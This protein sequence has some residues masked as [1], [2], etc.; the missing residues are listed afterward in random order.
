MNAAKHLEPTISEPLTWAAIC[1]RYPDEWV[2]LVEIDRIDPNNFEFR[3]AR[4]VGHGRTREDP[5]EQARP[6][7]QRYWSIGHYS[8]RRIVRDAESI[9][10]CFVRVDLPVGIPR[11]YAG[12]DLAD[13]IAVPVVQPGSDR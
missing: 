9:P 10:R 4:V 6:W 12:R 7:R 8:T 2:C 1:D 13:E 3:T 11:F 5:F